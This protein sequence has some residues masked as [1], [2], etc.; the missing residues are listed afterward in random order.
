MIR[1]A[2]AISLGGLLAGCFTEPDPACPSQTFLQI[3]QATQN[4]NKKDYSTIFRQ[5]RSLGFDT[6]TLQWTSY[7]NVNFYHHTDASK[8]TQTALPEIIRAA[9]RAGIHL[10]LGLHHDSRFWQL[11]EKSLPE[12]QTYFDTRLTDLESRLPDLRRLVDNADIPPDCIRG[13]YITDEID[14]MT[15]QDKQRQ[16]LLVKYLWSNNRLLRESQP[17]QAMKPAQYARFW[18][19]LILGGD[20]DVLFF[21][22]GIGAKKLTLERAGPYIKALKKMAGK[23]RRTLMVVVELFDSQVGSDEE[24]VLSAAA[25]GRVE[26]QLRL[27]ATAGIH[28]AAVFAAEPYLMH[29]NAPGSQQLEK[30]WRLRLLPLCQEGLQGS[31]N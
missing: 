21:Q 4:D 27:L 17:D 2:L 22:D 26:Q 3:Y 8:I 28:D 31:V 19:K 5:T 23:R 25:P 12:L 10:R 14:D 9:C 16:N 11:S 15:W 6:V 29:A 7:D 30:F 24:Q 13:W 20:I 1:F 18:D